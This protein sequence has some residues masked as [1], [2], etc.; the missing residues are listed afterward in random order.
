MRGLA[1]LPP[2]GPMLHDPVGEG[3]FKTNIAPGLFRFNP[4]VLEDLFS[5]GLKFAV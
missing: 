1:G 5:F 2:L 4:L 3:L